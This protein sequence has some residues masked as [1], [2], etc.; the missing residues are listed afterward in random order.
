MAEPGAKQAVWL[1][2]LVLATTPGCYRSWHS[3]KDLILKG[4]ESRQ[5]FLESCVDTPADHVD[6][7]REGSWQ[8]R[9]LECSPFGPNFN[10]WKPRGP[11]SE[12]KTTQNLFPPS[13]ALKALPVSEGSP[14]TP[15]LLCPTLFFAQMSGSLS[16]LRHCPW[17]ADSQTQHHAYD[18]SSQT[19]LLFP[20]GQSLRLHLPV[21]YF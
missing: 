13:S 14:T 9:V 5:R 21:L 6:S 7:C 8:L 16:R 3:A 2:C 4:G 17:E 19:G 18:L 12:C 11:T 1:Q 10:P 15:T 20:T